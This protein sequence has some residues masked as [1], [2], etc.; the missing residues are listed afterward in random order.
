MSS[1]AQAVCGG[2]TAAWREFKCDK[3]ASHRPADA[4]GAVSRAAGELPGVAVVWAPVETV[5]SGWKSL[6]AVDL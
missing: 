5:K 6:G 4:P 2:G 3:G 1:E